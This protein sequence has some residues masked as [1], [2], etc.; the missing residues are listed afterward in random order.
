MSKKFL[1]LQDL[2]LIKTSLEKVKMHV[3]EREDKSIFKWIKRESAVTISKC[4]KFPELKEPAEEMKKAIEGEDYEKL[5]EILPD[6][7]NKVE[8]KISEYYNSMQ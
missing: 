7:L 8:T 5:K 4:Y 6:L 3:N 2:I 1:D